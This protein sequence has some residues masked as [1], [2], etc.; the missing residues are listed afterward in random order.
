MPCTREGSPVE[1]LKHAKTVRSTAKAQ[2][3][4]DE[5]DASSAGAGLDQA[6]TDHA[7]C[8]QVAV[9][10]VSRSAN[11]QSLGENQPGMDSATRT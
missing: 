8:A 7:R 9:R 1:N 4:A 6:S 5:A 11:L 2:E 3:G 10:Q